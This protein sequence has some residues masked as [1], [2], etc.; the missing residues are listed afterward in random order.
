[1]S[2]EH[3]SAEHQAALRFKKNTEKGIEAAYNEAKSEYSN[4]VMEMKKAGIPLHKI[5]EE[6]AISYTYKLKKINEDPVSHLREDWSLPEFGETGRLANIAARKEAY[7][8]RQRQGLLRAVQEVVQEL[9]GEEELLLRT[10]SNSVAKKFANL[11]DAHQR[12]LYRQRLAKQ[13]AD[14]EATIAAAAAAS[15]AGRHNVPMGPGGGARRT[16]RRGSK[17][18][19]SRKRK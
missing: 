10:A 14:F 11:A 13:I 2:A 15:A 1:M 5:L 9:K 4:G 16:K 7:R 19:K 18:K 6:I 8:Y 17:S 3:K 12:E